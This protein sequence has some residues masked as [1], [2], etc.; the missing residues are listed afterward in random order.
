MITTKNTPWGTV[1]WK[2][3]GWGAF[4]MFVTLVVAFQVLV[5]TLT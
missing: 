5:L 4:W 1:Q 3:F 2:A